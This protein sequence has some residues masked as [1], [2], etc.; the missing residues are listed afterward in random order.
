MPAV[1]SCLQELHIK[2]EMF[3]QV[4]MGGLSFKRPSAPTVSQLAQVPH[5][6]HGIVMCGRFDC[7]SVFHHRSV[8]S[9]SLPAVVTAFQKSMTKYAFLFI[10]FLPPCSRP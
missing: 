4:G 10:F 5:V 2:A 9:T 7:L 1:L 6:L 3:L 8:L